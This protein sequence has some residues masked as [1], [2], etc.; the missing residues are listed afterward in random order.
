M[1]RLVTVAA[2]YDTASAY[3]ARATLEAAG[4]QVFLRN[5]HL[6]G[7]QSLYATAVGGVEVQVFA[8]DAQNACDIL[9]GEGLV[10]AGPEMAPEPEEQ[11]ACPVCGGT[12]YG[13]RNLGRASLALSYLV[14]FPLLFT[15]KRK[16]CAACGHI[17]KPKKAGTPRT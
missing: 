17:W 4:L 13:W 5:E 12:E 10:C 7:V 8:D 6:V 11:A 3:L 14:G 9:S 2:Y 1:S 15:F 16:R